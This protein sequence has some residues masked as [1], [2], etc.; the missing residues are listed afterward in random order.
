MHRLIIVVMLIGLLAS[1]DNGNGGATES[2][3][4]AVMSESVRD[5]EQQEAPVTASTQVWVDGVVVEAADERTVIQQGNAA[6]MDIGGRPIVF[7]WEGGAWQSTSRGLTAGER[8]CMSAV[9]DSNGAL[10]AGKTF[11]GAICGDI[12]VQE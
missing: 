6:T 5:S 1:C 2:P 3:T 11:S 7:D 12:R 9:L 8:I 10:I 4:P